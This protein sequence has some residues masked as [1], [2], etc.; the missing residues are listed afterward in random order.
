M[1]SLPVLLA[2]AVSTEE[3]PD[4]DAEVQLIWAKDQYWTRIVAPHTRAG[5]PPWSL[6]DAGSNS[7]LLSHL[8]A[9]SE[10]HRAR[11][12]REVLV[13]LRGGELR[14]LHAWLAIKKRFMP[15]VTSAVAN[16]DLLVRDGF[17]KLPVHE[18][19]EA[20]DVIAVHDL[21][22]WATP[23]GLQFAGELSHDDLI[24]FQWFTS[25]VVC[26]EDG[27]DLSGCPSD[28]W[29]D[30]RSQILRISGSP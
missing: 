27:W 5:L 2:L 30:E 20:E 25:V 10:L 9:V 24:A 11:R 18:A 28:E 21:N 14:M 13:V 3:E 4:D 17:T 26:Q 12:G 1:D 8:R 6:Y 22:R 16:G 29:D 23:L 19:R 7:V 15:R